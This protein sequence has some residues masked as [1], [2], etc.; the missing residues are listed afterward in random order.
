[1]I[2]KIIHYCWFGRKPIP[3]S[4]KKNIQS[5]HKF[6]PEYEIHEW[7][8][9]NY[10]V[11]CIPFSSEA[12]SIGKYAY[13]SDYARLRILYE[14]GGIYLDTDVELIKP[15]TKIIA[16]GPYM[17]FEK[18]CNAKEGELLNVALGLGFAVEPHNKLI[19]EIMSFYECHH[20]ITPDGHKEQ[21]TI[22][23]ITTDILKS[24]GLTRSDIPTNIDGITIY[25]WDYFCPIE[26]MS[27]KLEITPNTYTIHHYSASWMSWSDKLKMKKGYFAN[28]L[29]R[30]IETLK[31]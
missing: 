2:P 31:K 5:W 20:Y 15:L 1:M 28:K 25:P 17:A 21:I 12:Y 3:E 18:N 23:K 6:M 22:V 16:K 14:Y 27:N 9:L 24:K 10:D 26:F 30:F 29:R 4:Y 7:N 8:E 11:N 19:K 13:V